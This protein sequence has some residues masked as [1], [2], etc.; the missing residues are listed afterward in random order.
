MFNGYCFLVVQTA[1]LMLAVLLIFG[2]W[3]ISYVMAFV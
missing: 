1:A 2:L 3:F